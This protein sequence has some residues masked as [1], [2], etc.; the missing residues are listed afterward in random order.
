MAMTLAE[1]RAHTRSALLRDEA[2]PY[3]WTDAELDRYLNEAYRLFAVRTH[4]F[5]SEDEGRCYIITIPDV[6]LYEIDASIVAIKEAYVGD[7]DTGKLQGEL[8]I[9]DRTRGQLPYTNV[10]GRPMYMN[11]QVATHKVRVSP[12]PDA[13]YMINM[14]VA[15]KADPLEADCDENLLPEE[16]ELALCDY[17]AYRA[18]INNDPE[19]ANMASSKEF[20]AQWDMQVRD[21]KRD[22]AV[23]R[24]GPSAQARNNWTGKVARRRF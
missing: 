21:A 23:L 16:Y 8:I 15:H 24:A 22:F 1:L 4:C 18:L 7:A 13:A 19:K 5:V 9:R 6:D 20:K 17:A 14:H 2:V 10:G 3:L 11:A 12:V